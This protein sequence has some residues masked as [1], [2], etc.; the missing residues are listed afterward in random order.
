MTAQRSQHKFRIAAKKALIEHDLT[1]TAL[2]KQ[3]GYARN[4]VSMAINH[5]ILPGVR[6]EIA[7]KLKLEGMK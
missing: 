7:K 3:L 6:R 5:A 2:A 1:I 4:S